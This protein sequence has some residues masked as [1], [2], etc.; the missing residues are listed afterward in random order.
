[1][2]HQDLELKSSSLDLFQ[3]VVV[4]GNLS[5]TDSTLWEIKWLQINSL[6]ESVEKAV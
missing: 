4:I 5:F 3:I 6:S 2:F 1:M